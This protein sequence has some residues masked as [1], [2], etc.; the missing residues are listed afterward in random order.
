MSRKRVIDV[1]A[2]PQQLVSF[3]NSLYKNMLVTAIDQIYITENTSNI[4]DGDLAHRLALLPVKQGD[5][6]P[7]ILV[8]EAKQRP[9]QVTS[10]DILYNDGGNL[11][12]FGEFPI[13]LLQPG[14]RIAMNIS[15]NW[16]TASDHA[17]YTAFHTYAFT[18]VDKNTHR[19]TIESDH[20][21]V[22]RIIAL[23]G[24]RI[25]IGLEE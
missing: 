11:L 7:M 22:D 8:A 15:T 12:E 24:V 2:D 23:S 10:Y 16:G 4:K 18:K 5:Y 6:G 17:K 20:I 9:Y 14:Q 21:N 3:R 1:Q 13:V 25:P 19:L